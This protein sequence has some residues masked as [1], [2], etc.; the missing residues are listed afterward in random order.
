[1]VSKSSRRNQKA[2]INYH[3][4]SPRQNRETTAEEKFKEAAVKLRSTSDADK[5][6]L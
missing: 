1:M 6:S 5:S 2:S 4:I 3:Q